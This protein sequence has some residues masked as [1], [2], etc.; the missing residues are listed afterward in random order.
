MFNLPFL[1]LIFSEILLII[2]SIN[3]KKKKVLIS[4]Y[5]NICEVLFQKSFEINEHTI[6]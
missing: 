4:N 2:T 6:L 5:K 1:C 3:F